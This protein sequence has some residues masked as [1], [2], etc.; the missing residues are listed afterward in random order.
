M[1]RTRHDERQRARVQAIEHAGSRPAPMWVASAAPNARASTGTSVSAR[2][3]DT[4]TAAVSVID[5]AR[6]K[7]PTVPDSKPERHEHDHRRQRRADDGAG[8]LRHRRLERPHACAFAAAPRDV[9]HDHDRVI[10][11]EAD[12]DRQPAH[13]HQVDRLPRDPHQEEGREHGERQRQRR[14]EGEAPVAQEQQEHDDSEQAPEQDRVAD[15]RH[16]GGHEFGEVVRLREPKPGGERAA[17][18][19]RAAPRRPAARRARWRPPAAT[20]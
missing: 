1:Q 9:L 18:A 20:R 15:V 16:G 11:H 3:S 4:S 19:T 12:G 5:S 6:K 13:R 17:K 2:A 7:S 14:H 10:D 8:D